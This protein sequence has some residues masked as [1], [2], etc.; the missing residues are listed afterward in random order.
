MGAPGASGDPARLDSELGLPRE[1]VH[2][3]AGAYA[4]LREF[5]WT[6]RLSPFSFRAF[7]L[8]MASPSPS[9]VFDEVHVSVLRLL[10][11]DEPREERELWPL[12][13]DLLDHVTWSEFAWFYVRALHEGWGQ[14]RHRQVVT[15]GQGAAED[16]AASSHANPSS[17]SLA[18]WARE[19]RR[20]ADRRGRPVVSDYYQLPL[21]IK[22]DI[23]CRLLDEALET[24]LVRTELDRRERLVVEGLNTL[25]LPPAAMM[26]PQAE[27]EPEKRGPGR[28][29]KYPLEAM[30]E[31]EPPKRRPGRPPK[32]VVRTAPTDSEE[33][34]GVG[35]YDTC[36]LCGFGG[37]LICCDGCPAT[38]HMKCCGENRF[39]V[40]DEGEWLCELCRHRRS[41]GEVMVEKASALTCPL[42]ID[43]A[44]F[45][46]RGPRG[47]RWD[48]WSLPGFAVAHSSARS[49]ATSSEGWEWLP[50]EGPSSTK[51]LERAFLGLHGGSGHPKKTL[52]PL[53]NS[54]AGSI[55]TYV[56]KFKTAWHVVGA[57]L[58]AREK[59]AE[60][61]RNKPKKG[62]EAFTPP[63]SFLPSFGV[64]KFQWPLAANRSFQVASE[65]AEGAL[66]QV[67]ALESGHLQQLA[68]YVLR[69]EKE[70]WGLLQGPWAG[71]PQLRYQWIQSVRTAQSVG[72]L[73]AAFLELD[74]QVPARLRKPGWFQNLE[75]MGAQA[76]SGRDATPNPGPQL[77][78]A[79]KIE[80]EK[81][82]SVADVA[83]AKVYEGT[84]GDGVTATPGPVGAT[85]KGA[86]KVENPPS[87]KL[88]ARE[89]QAPVNL[90]PGPP[91]LNRGPGRPFKASRGPGS[92]PKKR[93]RPPKDSS[94][95]QKKRGPGRPP[96]AARLETP[97]SE[98]RSSRRISDLSIKA[99]EVGQVET[100]PAS[101]GR[102]AA[103]G[104]GSQGLTVASARR[105][106][107]EENFGWPYVFLRFSAYDAHGRPRARSAPRQAMPRTRKRMEALLPDWWRG[108]L[109]GRSNNSE[110]VPRDQLRRCA[111]Q[112]GRKRLDGV[113]Y[114]N[115]RRYARPGP[116]AAWA[117]RVEACQTTA[118]L[119]LLLREFDDSLLWDCFRT[120]PKIDR[121]LVEKRVEEETGVI[122][123]L[124]VPVEKRK[125]KD[126]DE[127]PQVR[128]E[129]SPTANTKIAGGKKVKKGWLKQ[130]EVPLWLLKLYEESCRT[131]AR[132]GTRTLV[133]REDM[134]ALHEGTE[135]ELYWADDNSWYHGEIVERQLDGSVKVL[136]S[137]GDVEA[138]SRLD[139]CSLVDAGGIACKNLNKLKK[140]LGLSACPQGATRAGE[141]GRPKAQELAPGEL[142]P[143][144][145]ALPDEYE[146][147]TALELQLLLADA[148]GGAAGA[149]SRKKMAKWKTAVKIP[150]D[151]LLEA[152][153]VA[154]AQSPQERLRSAWNAE[155]RWVADERGLRDEREA[156][157]LRKLGVKDFPKA[158]APPVWNP[159]PTRQRVECVNLVHMVAQMRDHSGRAMGQTFMRL[160]K[161]KQ[162]PRYF[163]VIKRPL[164]LEVITTSLRQRPG[165]PVA[166]PLAEGY[167][168][169]E[170]FVSDMETLFQNAQDFHQEGSQVFADAHYCRKAFRGRVQKS[171]PKCDAE[172]VAMFSAEPG[173]AAKWKL[174][175]LLALQD[176]ADKA[177]AAREVAMKK[178]MQREPPKKKQKTEKAA[179]GGSSGTKKKPP[180]QQTRQPRAQ[181][182]SRTEQDLK[183]CL[184]VLQELMSA[185]EAA[186]F[187]E[188]VDTEVFPEYRKIVRRPMNLGTIRE[189][190]EPNGQDLGRGD[191]HYSGEAEVRR[192]VEQ[193]WKNCRKFNFEGDPIVQQCSSMEARF[194]DL[195][196]GAFKSGS[197]TARA[198]E[199]GSAAVQVRASIADTPKECRL[200]WS[201]S[202]QWGDQWLPGAVLAWHAP[203]GQSLVEYEDGTLA[204]EVLTGKKVVWGEPG[205]AHKLAR[206]DS[207]PPSGEAA[208]GRRVGVWWEST[209]SLFYGVVTAFDKGRGR[210]MVQYD[211]GDKKVTELSRRR[212]HWVAA[213]AKSPVPQ[214]DAGARIRGSQAVGRALRVWW[215][216]DASFYVA[217][218]EEFDTK[219]GRHRLLYDDGSEEWLRLSGVKLEWVQEPVV[220]EGAECV[221]WRVGVW[222]EREKT[223][224]YGKV[225]Q[226]DE[227]RSR[228]RVE[229][230]D[231]DKR[232]INLEKKKVEWV[233]P[234]LNGE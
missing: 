38:F 114:T 60:K 62:T 28:P 43:S 98:R 216:A 107:D 113:T 86:A 189:R 103:A 204:W 75:D 46:E 74:A 52:L 85:G 121:K 2:R 115:A 218:V 188:P 49:G 150:R 164:D 123:Y 201:V 180:A 111:R 82:E 3:L 129:P 4:L 213:G 230:D 234:T 233:A 135:I 16:A 154:R 143:E 144:A 71:P 186:P 30:V 133:S 80:G 77:T 12:N 193:V 194:Q 219:S 35:N 91:P 7:A 173:K 132:K 208:V 196:S 26:L 70:A 136:Y 25:E 198:G 42:R 191:P 95:P 48:A 205:V 160:A 15:A 202:V 155:Q 94:A 44:K 197:G 122:E 220:P 79:T 40:P 97:A 67:L 140:K 225:T 159:F 29:R 27:P 190:L 61:M 209:K 69:V 93:G 55:H 81:L 34:E 227:D 63:T 99:Q 192:D 64:N 181:A 118:Q 119:A 169:L 8:A 128:T 170:E 214:P 22:L 59:K 19:R 84:N 211:D 156:A 179:A 232:W 178:A 37:Y 139:F 176:K 124:Q 145:K 1:Q 45:V 171:F 134:E 18:T 92:P 13:L 174:Q 195:W 58:A 23:L 6:L 185:P 138:L 109:Y 228:W 157:D 215:P 131:Q 120:P 83:N 102:G 56:N 117:A 177:D 53:S 141:P 112:G 36:V 24:T 100:T 41:E 54:E 32:V 223:V 76:D 10:V 89:E 158:C 162:E 127:P 72:A 110:Q 39:T 108:G 137:N 57:E 222:W 231:G 207:V 168:F 212:V 130:S 200:G 5:C 206:V 161:P 184:K 21:G 116:A 147:L 183:K 47:R 187:N 221:G 166:P 199:E 51:D 17:G 96:K 11:M 148:S 151:R 182:P 203:T 153:T 87:A 224:F 142:P 14:H 165:F 172:H 167:Y 20:I 33:E 31:S 50:R 226:F 217:R 163:K 90:V 126:G 104:A 9:P 149:L 175:Q 101:E 229:Y 105:A 146:L 66:D 152:V 88:E 68:G 65:K 125:G 210:H 78:P 73:L 106:D